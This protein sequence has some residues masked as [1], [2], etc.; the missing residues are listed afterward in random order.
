[1]ASPQK[2]NGYTTISNELLEALCKYKISSTQLRI[3]LF[4]ARYTYGFGRKSAE[5]SNSFISVGIGIDK[6]KIPREIRD[7]I[8]KNIV[9]ITQEPTFSKPRKIGINK[10]Y[11]S[12]QNWGQLPK[13]VPPAEIGRSPGTRI[14]STPGTET[15]TQE[16]KHRENYKENTLGDFFESVWTLYPRKKGKADIKLSQQ[17]VLYK[18]GYDKLA[19]AIKRYDDSVS[20]KTYLMYGGKF[21]NSGYL[22]WLE[23]EEIKTDIVQNNEERVS[24]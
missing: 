2:E 15:G 12:W 19:E 17:K 7:L 10:N 1:M 3:L 14:G 22:D 13:M 8:S 5:L 9:V 21:F 24:Y 6:S 20:D 16:R 4:I 11:E 18:I 23:A